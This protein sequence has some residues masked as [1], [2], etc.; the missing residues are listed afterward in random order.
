MGIKIIKWVKGFLNGANHVI[1]SNSYNMSI[2]TNVEKIKSKIY[3][4]G[5][6]HVIK[7]SLNS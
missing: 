7:L 6:N 3:F 2:Q 4:Y 5:A 1:K